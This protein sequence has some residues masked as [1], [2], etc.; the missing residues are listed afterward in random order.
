[1]RKEENKEYAS[2]FNNAMVTYSNY[3]TSAMAEVVDFAR[4]NTLVDIAGGLGTLL[5]VILEKHQNLRGIS[6]DLAH[7][8]ENAKT[9]TP[10]EF[11]RKQIAMT[12]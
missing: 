4:F 5:S 2:L 10:N 7:D 6:F 8:I 12:I 1:M 9:N 11:Q 3:M